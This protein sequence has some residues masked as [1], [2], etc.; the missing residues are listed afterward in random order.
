MGAK[1][2]IEG[3]IPRLD[4]QINAH[5]CCDAARRDDQAIGLM[6][7]DIA[8]GQVVGFQGVN[9]CINICIRSCGCTDAGLSGE[10]DQAGGGDVGCFCRQVIRDG[11]RCGSPRTGGGVDHA[12]G[13][14]QLRQ[15][16]IPGG[17]VI[18]GTAGSGSCGT[19][20]HRNGAAA[21]CQV[22]CAYAGRTQAAILINAAAGQRNRPAR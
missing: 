2:T 14:D 7:D 12:A 1:G 5:V 11:A 6:N 17:A 3:Q 18:D 16:D 13:A 8:A 19:A 4:C 21:G 10:R 9:R 20:G 15:G 22:D